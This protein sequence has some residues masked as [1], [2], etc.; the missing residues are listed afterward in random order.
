MWDFITNNFKALNSHSVYDG[1]KTNSQFA[2]PNNTFKYVLVIT[3]YLFNVVIKAMVIMH[4]CLLVCWFTLLIHMVNSVNS[5]YCKQR[6]YPMLS[7][8]EK[9]EFHRQ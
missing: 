8:R 5:E 2:L 7:L 1:N 6:Y 9:R 4:K 3:Q